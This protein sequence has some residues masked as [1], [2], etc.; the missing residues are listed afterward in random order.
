[1]NRACTHQFFDLNLPLNPLGRIESGVIIRNGTGTGFSRM[2][3]WAQYQ[4]VLIL[5][6]EGV[7]RDSEGRDF[8]VKKGDLFVTTPHVAHQYGPQD[9]KVWDELAIGFCGKL[10][11]LWQQTGLLHPLEKPYILT[12]FEK[13][14]RELRELLVP[15]R[16]E[17]Q[18]PIRHLIRLQTL[19]E[20]LAFDQPAKV[21]HQPEWLATA[22]G[23]I[24]TPD[25]TRPPTVNELAEACGLGVHTFRREFA[26]HTGVGPVAYVHRIRMERARSLL[27]STDLPIKVIAQQLGFSDAF[28]FSS[29]FKKYAGW[30]PR[31][32]KEE[33]LRV[34][35]HFGANNDNS[36]PA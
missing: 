5:E 11:D 19:L 31:S 34:N 27:T 15:N 10:F 12:P 21:A 32:F 36:H 17:R 23:M 22:L 1:M 24:D 7:Y 20:D 4:L 18:Q 29:A 16:L 33:F 28:H 3:R 13:W 14:Y 25:L 2:R 8:A 6:G 9:G 30:S 35:P 26:R